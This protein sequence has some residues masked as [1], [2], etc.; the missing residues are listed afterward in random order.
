MWLYRS[1][2][3][4]VV[5]GLRT[6]EARHFA[7][8]I[9][10][11]FLPALVAGVLLA[12]F[13]KS[14]IYESADVIA[15]AFVAG[16]MV[17]LIVERFRPRPM[18]VDAA[19]TTVLSCARRRCCQAA[20]AG[21]RRVALGATIVGG[22]LRA[23]IGPPPPSSRSFWRCRRWPPR[24]C[25]SM[26]E[27]RHSSRAIAA[28]EI[29][30]GFV[31]AFLASALVVKPFLEFVPRSGFA[32]FAWYRIVVGLALFAAIA[33]GS[34]CRRMQWL[35]R[36]FIAGLFVTVPLVVSVAA[37]VWL[38]RIVDGLTTPLYERLLGPADARASA[39]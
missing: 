38:F 33:A 13:V 1:K 14:V 39:S 26:L 24:S 23:S 37:F 27:V 19:R 10:V 20:G 9:V 16:G 18:V 28:L 36:S 4:A 17:M 12:E 7:I 21:S 2:F 30:V 35:R 8:M 15:I 22:L 3:T 31:A 5:G 6:A 34:S 29:A 11:A 32:P 25:T